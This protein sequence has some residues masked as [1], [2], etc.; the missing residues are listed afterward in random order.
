MLL[1]IGNEG[2]TKICLNLVK[3]ICGDGIQ[4][5][6]IV[7]QIDQIKSTTSNIRIEGTRFFSFPFPLFFSMFELNRAYHLSAILSISYLLI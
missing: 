1:V 2:K 7:N 4:Y 6:D 3:S 5:K